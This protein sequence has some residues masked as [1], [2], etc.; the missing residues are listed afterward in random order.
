MASA[1]HI[2]AAGAYQHEFRGGPPTNDNCAS[3]QALTVGTDCLAPTA[4]D[5]TQ[6]TQSVLGPACDPTTTGIYA[7]VWYS[8]NSG[9]NTSVLV[10]L[11]PSLTMTDNVLVVLDGC[12]GTELLCFVL[13][14]GPQAV[15]VST[16]TNYFIRVYSNT[17]YGDPGPFTIC[18]R[19]PGAAPANDDCAGAISLPVNQNCVPTNGT[20]SGGTQS[21]AAIAC[22]TFTGDANDDVWYSFTATA[23]TATIE[24]DGGTDFDAVVD[25]RSG[26]CNGTNLACADATVEDEVESISA[27]GLTIGAVYFIRVYSYGTTAPVDPTFT[28]CVSDGNGGS[29]PPNDLCSNVTPQVLTA[30]GSLTFTGTSLNALNTEGY[31]WA[32][33]WEAFTIT[34][35]MDV[36]WDFCGSLD[37]MLILTGALLGC[38]FEGLG[39]A[40]EYPEITCPDGIQLS[41]QPSMQDLA[42]DTYYILIPY[43]P[44]T[45]GGDYTIN[46]T[47]VACSTPVPANDECTA[48]VQLAV[49]ASCVSTAG[50]CAGATRSLPNV[51]C[52]TTTGQADDDVW[53]SFTATYPGGSIFVTP[54][55][56]L[57]AVVQLYDGTCAGLTPLACADGGAVGFEEELVYSG[58]NV[59]TTY[60]YR[61][62]SYD[63][64]TYCNG[65]FTTCVIYTTSMGVG[66]NTAAE[67]TVY[68]NPGNGDFTVHNGG[69]GGLVTM[70]VMDLGGRLVYSTTA[71]MSAGQSHNLA[72]AG[73]L[74][75][76][77]YTLRISNGGTSHEQRLMVK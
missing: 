13:P 32:S 3:A 38:P 56:S 53:Y 20:T 62:H 43:V 34:Q 65:S 71:Q 69:A 17:Q 57:D 74:A 68:P 48:A 31:P 44:G 67:M 15:V 1:N 40:C 24:V 4:G 36:T 61:V 28:I 6:A 51:T 9:S 55:D 46:M 49:G 23:T 42:P 25:L 59:G 72:L 29:V 2:H 8:F 30:G 12:T 26:A 18:V 45:Y 50:T 73:I 60:Y 11:V 14:V 39:N 41:F 75:Q 19:T 66:S 5:N 77:S 7:D 76:G 22:G 27:T 64:G 58:L 16:N 33:V 54:L 35:C 10:D 52:G 70:E 63:L 47:G 21:L 37:N